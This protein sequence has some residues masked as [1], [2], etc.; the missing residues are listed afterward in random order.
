MAYASTS[1]ALAS[2]EFFVHL[3]GLDA[4][5]GLVSLQVEIPDDVLVQRLYPDQ[6]PPNWRDYPGPQTLREIGNSWMDG[7]SSVCLMV[8]SVVI[9]QE[10]NLLINATH[11]DFARLLVRDPVAFDFDPR[12]WKR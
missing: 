10:Y 1:L 11:P 12:L 8:P 7:G 4:P 5:E 9:P 6:L 3:N 2:V